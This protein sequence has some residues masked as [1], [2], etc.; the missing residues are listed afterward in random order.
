M[1]A[2]HVIFKTCSKLPILKKYIADIELNATG[3]KI[4]QRCTE[5]IGAKF[6]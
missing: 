2:N 6:S 5:S 3:E 1:G 4:I